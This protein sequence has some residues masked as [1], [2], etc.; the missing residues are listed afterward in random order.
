MVIPGN[1]FLILT[2]GHRRV[3]WCRLMC[4]ESPREA[5]RNW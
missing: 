3:C 2:L 4:D 5:V 1:M